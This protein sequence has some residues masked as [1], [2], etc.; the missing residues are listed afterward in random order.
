VSKLAPFQNCDT[1]RRFDYPECHAPTVCDYQPKQVYNPANP[2]DNQPDQPDKQDT[3]MTD[4]EVLKIV[5][6]TTTRWERNRKLVIAQDA[7]TSLKLYEEERDFYNSLRGQTAVSQWKLINARL[8]YL[9]IKIAELIKPSDPA[10]TQGETEN[11]K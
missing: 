7:H 10:Q 4:E 2:V 1:C 9:D 6:L 5:T 11:S 8:A 3:V